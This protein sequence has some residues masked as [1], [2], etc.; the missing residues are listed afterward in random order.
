MIVAFLYRRRPVGS[1]SELQSSGGIVDMRIV[2]TEALILDAQIKT[3]RDVE[4]H[5]ASPCEVGSLFIEAGSGNR[6]VGSE[7]AVRLPEK[8]ARLGVR[9]NDGKNGDIQNGA[10]RPAMRLDVV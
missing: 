3:L 2:E 1:E 6:T 4:T 9:R 10:S 7:C 5:T 8:R